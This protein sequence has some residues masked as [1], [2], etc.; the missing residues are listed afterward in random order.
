[1]KYFLFPIC[2]LVWSISCA[3]LVPCFDKIPGDPERIEVE[4]HPDSEL[5]VKIMYYSTGLNDKMVSDTI[6]TINP[7]TQAVTVEVV[8]RNLSLNDCDKAEIEEGGN[9]YYYF[10]TPKEKCYRIYRV[11]KLMPRG[12]ED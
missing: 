12:K 3:Q 9:K 4:K 10:R 7:E 11:E 1:M 5:G 6:F 8:E 2:L